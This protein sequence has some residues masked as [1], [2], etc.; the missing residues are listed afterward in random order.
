MVKVTW[1]NG[2]GRVVQIKHNGTYLTQYAHLSA[3]AKGLRTGDHVSQGELIGYVGQSGHATGPHLDFRVQQNGKWVNPLGLK[4]G[5]SAPLP[6]SQKPAFAATVTRWNGLLDELQ[7]GATIRL[8]ADGSLPTPATA[9][10]R[11]DTQP[12][13]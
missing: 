7:A 11:V 5:E 10:A 13:S 1:V 3:Y 2:F 8:D 6:D 4:R 9:S 12:T